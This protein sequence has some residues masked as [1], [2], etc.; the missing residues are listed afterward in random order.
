[1]HYYLIRKSLYYTCRN[2]CSLL[3]CCLDNLEACT[4]CQYLKA[5]SFCTRI[6][7]LCGVLSGVIMNSWK[8]IGDKFVKLVGISVKCNWRSLNLKNPDQ[9]SD[10]HN[11]CF[12][13]YFYSSIT[14]NALQQLIDKKGQKNVS[15]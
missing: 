14:L 12:L 11:N 7:S 6:I 15:Y 5:S 8:W 9:P 3:L 4:C 13:V 1:M 10:L 2:F